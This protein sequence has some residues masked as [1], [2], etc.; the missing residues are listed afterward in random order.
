M[1]NQVSPI[2]M[3]LLIKSKQPCPF[4]SSHFNPLAEIQFNQIALLMCGINGKKW[5]LAEVFVY[6][7]RLSLKCRCFIH[8]AEPGS[9]PFHTFALSHPAP[10]QWN[11]QAIV[12]CPLHPINLS[13]TFLRIKGFNA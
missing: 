9:V 8:V 12:L 3:T 10:A 4:H 6:C 1:N 7:F 2:N 13:P 5:I 11:N